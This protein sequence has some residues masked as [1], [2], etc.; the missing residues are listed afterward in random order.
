MEKYFPP[1]YNIIV[2]KIK[3]LAY[4]HDL[5]G[6][7]T[8]DGLVIKHHKL[9]RSSN[10]SKIN[11]EGVDRLADNFK[12]KRV[13]DLRTEEEIKQNPEDFITTRIEYLH[14]PSLTNEQN[15]AINKL[16]RL[17]ILDALVHL[18][19][20]VKAHMKKLYRTLVNSKK[21][22]NVYKEVFKNLL[23]DSN[24]GA[25]LY[26][27][28]QGKDRTGVLTYLILSALGVSS[29]TASN[30]YMSFN[31]RSILKRVAILVIIGGLIFIYFITK[32]GG[33]GLLKPHQIA[34]FITWL[35]PLNDK[36]IFGTSYQ[37]VNGMVGYSN[38]GLIGRGFGNSIMKYGYIPEAQNDYISAIIA[39]EFGLLGMVLLL[40]PYCVIIYRLFS[41]AMKMEDRRSKLILIGVASYFFFHLLVNLGGVSGLIPMTGV[42]LLLVSAGGTSTLAALTALGIA[43]NIIGKYNRK[44]MQAL[45]EKEIS[46]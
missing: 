6:I 15:P 25:I 4:I 38:G 22:Q 7:L 35:D 44:Q 13:I 36:Y 28:T 31:R 26:H 17:E 11:S 42:P 29:I 10:L 40:I 24:D 8:K 45:A 19:G 2:K 32:M 43:Q 30:V 20:G 5:G 12:V 3:K 21:A 41:Y 33:A 27:C 16:N 1:F 37:I 46:E 18:K 39:E 34:R 23:D 14:L 9:I